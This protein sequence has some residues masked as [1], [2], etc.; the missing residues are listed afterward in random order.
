LSDITAAPQSPIKSGASDDSPITLAP[1]NP[2]ANS[3][4]SAGLPS[5][6]VPSLGLT[7]RALSAQPSA[8]SDRPDTALGFQGISDSSTPRSQPV[9]TPTFTPPPHED[10]GTGIQWLF[11]YHAAL[12]AARNQGKQVLVFFSARGNRVATRYTKE[13][14]REPAVRTALDRFLLVKLDFPMNTRLGYR[15][16]IFGAGQLVIVNGDD[17]KIGAITQMPASPAEFVGALN[18]I[19]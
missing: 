10:D 11:D 18:S 7:G 16:G 8:T 13:F 17:T 14:F 9:A 2:I 1:L 6:A 3:G 19:K 12:S 4:S 15:L 5:L